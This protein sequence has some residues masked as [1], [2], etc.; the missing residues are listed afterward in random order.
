M[1]VLIGGILLIVIVIALVIMI[2]YGKVDA[3]LL[4]STFFV[5]LGFFFGQGVAA[6]GHRKTDAS[7]NNHAE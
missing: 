7:S 5:L 1:S 4:E 6:R 3:R 2:F